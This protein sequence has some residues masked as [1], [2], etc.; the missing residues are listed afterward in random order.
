MS[1]HCTWS[2]LWTSACSGPGVGE[3]NVDMHLQIFNY[4]FIMRIHSYEHQN[5]CQYCR[6]LRVFLVTQTVHNFFR[7]VY[8]LLNPNDLWEERNHIKSDAFNNGVVKL[9]MNGKFTFTKN[10]GNSGCLHF[11]QPW[12]EKLLLFLS[13]IPIL[14]HWCFVYHLQIPD[15]LKERH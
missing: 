13:N 10:F 1:A 9:F 14:I 2:S 8:V 15:A 7:G 4:V 3:H 6:S 5:K 12:L 11:P